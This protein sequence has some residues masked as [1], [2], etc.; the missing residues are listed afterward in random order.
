MKERKAAT[1]DWRLCDVPAEGR[2][3]TL[4]VCQRSSASLR[5]RLPSLGS[6]MI[7]ALRGVGLVAAILTFTPRL[8]L[9]MASDGAL[10]TNVVSATFGGMGGPTLMY[11]VSYNATS[12]VLISCP[13][14]MLSKQAT[15]TVQASGSV[16]VFQIW[17]SNAS[18]QASAFNV[19][20]TDMIP[21]NMTYVNPSESVWAGGATGLTY[22]LSTNTV[23][24]QTSGALIQP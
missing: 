20:I 8:A 16:V 15:P 6:P 3:T 21:D 1:N 24:W 11:T 12:N 14:V 22:A 17:I 13:A 2:E 9:G 19:E 4:H 5:G 7:R 10:I 23:A 18:M